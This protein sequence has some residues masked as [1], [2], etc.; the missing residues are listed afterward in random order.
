MPDIELLHIESIVLQPLMLYETITSTPARHGIGISLTRSP[1]KR[2]TSNSTR[3]CTIPATG[4]FPPLFM[5]AIVRAIAPVAGIPPKNGTTIFATPW[6]ISSVLELWRSPITPSATIAESRDSI[7][8]NIAIVNAT[9]AR[10]CIVEKSVVP[11]LISG[12]T[13]GGMPDGNV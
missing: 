12:K 3:V 6:P 10:F 2:S 8:P 5:L 1:R 9:G 11:S 13:K 4:V 7:A